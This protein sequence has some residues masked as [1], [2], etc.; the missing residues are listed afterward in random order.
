M[1][2]R[3]PAQRHLRLDLLRCFRLLGTLAG[4]SS[5][6]EAPA[7]SPSAAAV[8]APRCLRCA[9]GPSGVGDSAVPWEP[10]KLSLLIAGSCP[11]CALLRRDAGPHG[12]SC[13]RIHTAQHALTFGGHDRPCTM[14]HNRLMGA[15]GSPKNMGMW[16]SSSRR[17]WQ[18]HGI[19]GHQW[20]HLVG[21]A[22]AAVLAVRGPLLGLAVVV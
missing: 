9:V 21:G 12:R 19:C 2:L 8:A 16:M 11:T 18:S 3:R 17:P 15:C 1:S 14:V 6:L 13:G 4:R 7:S 22:A 5:P 20:A 10:L